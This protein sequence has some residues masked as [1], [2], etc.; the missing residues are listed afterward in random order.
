M[1]KTGIS[2]GRKFANKTPEQQAASRKAAK[3]AGRA[4]LVGMSNSE[5]AKLAHF[6]DACVL[7]DVQPTKRQASKYRRGYGK[8]AKI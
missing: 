4:N 1:M 8:A 7:A 3:A 5:Y 2:G 6:T